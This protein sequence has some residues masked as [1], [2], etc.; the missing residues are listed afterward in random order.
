MARAQVAAAE[1]EPAG[2]VDVRV[3]EAR[4]HGPPA[5][6]R[7]ASRSDEPPQERR[8]TD[9]TAMR[10]PRMAIESAIERAASTV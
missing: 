9:G 1:P 4:Q 10:P 8:R 3:A 7:R 5:G 2:D 6:R